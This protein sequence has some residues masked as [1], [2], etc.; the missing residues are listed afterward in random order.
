M[1]TLVTGATGFIGSVLVRQLVQRGDT[2]RALALPGEET[3]ALSSMG[4]EIAIGDLNTPE[5]LRGICNGIDTVYH[6]AGRVTDWGTK[7]QFYTAIYNATENLLKEAAGNA[8]R[9]VYVSSIAAMGLG[10]H[11]KGARET[12]QTRT[13]G[14]PYNDAKADTEALVLSYHQNRIID[15]VI[16]RPAN[17]TGPGSVWVRDIVERMMVMP[18]PLIDR[19]RYSTSFVSVESLADG[20]IRAGTNRNAPGRAYHFRD[21]WDV[22]WK[23]Y[24]T[25]LGSF[26]GR[27]P[28]ASIPFRAAWLAGSICE[29]LAAPFNI[30]PPVTRL[31]VSVMGRDND[32]DTFL[33]RNELGWKSLVSYREAI[34]NIGAW[35]KETYAPVTRAGDTGD[36]HG[37]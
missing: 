29:F 17:V 28:G 7:R 33:A 4:V 36:K 15:C 34:N 37:V 19:G 31:A 35:V 32:V 22:T 10:R 3:S 5:T 8:S 24:I 13:S 21:D 26:I 16:V 9:F 11:L 23:E 20:I 6:L 1:K 27:R 2:V 18:V 30:R 25:D 12:D 14:V